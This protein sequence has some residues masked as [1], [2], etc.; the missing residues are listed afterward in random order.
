MARRIALVSFMVLWLLP[1]L[2]LA[3]SKSH[4]TFKLV[5]LGVMGGIDESNLS[6]YMLAPK[7]SSNYVCL[8]AGTLHYGIEQAV[9]N[10]VFTVGADKVLK[11]YIK[12]YLISHAHLDH[13]AGLIINSPDDSAKT[14]YGLAS[15]L[16]TLQTHYFTWD[17]WANFADEGEKP[18]LK[19]YHYQVLTPDSTLAIKNTAMTV[20]A[21]PLSHSNL[22]STAF[23]VEDDGNYLLYLGDT[24]PDEVEKSQN[25]HNLWKAVAPLVANKKLKAMM[26]ETSFPDEQPD[27][28]LFGHLT[29]HWLMKEMDDLA[30]L[31]GNGTL[32]GFNVIITHEKPPKYKMDEIKRQLNAEN[33]LQLN[34]VFPQ[35]G[36]P[37]DL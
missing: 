21:F 32:K 29:P 7:G 18:L 20:K 14:I 16:Q 13:V 31:S 3:Q 15:C 23:L 27:K 19:K 35:Q 33:K 36:K 37:I 6:A 17:S 28:T 11:Q 5:P 12:G 25:L 8:D 24:G 26:I 9:K 4:Y 10:K 30:S 34:L 1:M 22:T 2:I